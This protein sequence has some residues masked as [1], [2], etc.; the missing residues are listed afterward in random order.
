MNNEFHS[1]NHFRTRSVAVSKNG[2]VATSQPLAVTTGLD[3]LK[4]GGNAVDAAIAANAMLGVVEPE[5]CGIGGDLFA[6]V[7]DNKSQKLYGLN[8][9][10]RA[11]YDLTI[12]K[13]HSQ[14]LKTTSS[15]YQGEGCDEVI[16]PDIGPLTW[17]VPGCVDGWQQLNSR[18]GKKTLKELLSPAITYAEI[19]FP[20]TEIISRDWQSCEEKLRAWDTSAQT[21][22]PQGRAPR[23]GEMFRNPQLAK[24]L[25]LIGDY[26]KGEF[27]RGDITDKILQYSQANGGYFTKQDFLDHT[28]TWVNPIAV[29]YRGYEVWEIPPN[30]QGITVLEMLNILE[31]FDIA[32][33]GHNSADYIH[34]FAEAKKLAYADRAKYYADPE[35]SQVPIK[36]LISKEYA[37]KQREQID[38]DCALQPETLN[39]EL[40]I[41]KDTVYVTVVDKERNCVSL[42]QSIYHSFGSGMVPGDLGFALQNR[43]RGFSLNPAHPNC[44]MPHKR[45]FHTIIPAFVTKEGKPF[46][47][48]GVIGGVFQPQGQVQILCNIIDFKMDPQLAGDVPRVRHDGSQEPSGEKMINGGWISIEPSIPESIREQL[49]QKGHRVEEDSHGYGGYQGIMLDSENGTLLGG[50]DPRKDG[51]ALGY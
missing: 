20:V 43:G 39:S 10:G 32:S 46:F 1:K 47:S 41:G 19:G 8:A 7:W 15:P 4:R 23:A 34:L 37:Q 29:D 31:L 14:G 48:F 51:L 13:V 3:I 22:L 35:F 50:S 40:E 17:T 18:F 24:T 21:F 11:P 2:M 6:I 12:E 16:M 36:E 49:R 45:P 5:S 26:G 30:G 44:L 33:L 9:S 25:R 27:Y 28:S 38:M 42:I